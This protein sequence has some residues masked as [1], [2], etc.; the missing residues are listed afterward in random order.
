MREND[1]INPILFEM[2][3]CEGCQLGLDLLRDWS[4]CSTNLSTSIKTLRAIPRMQK[5]GLVI[6]DLGKLMPESLNLQ[7]RLAPFTAFTRRLEHA[8]L[9]WRY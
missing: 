1:K 9:S 5:E 4:R 8:H 3:S 7:T 6:L 2:F